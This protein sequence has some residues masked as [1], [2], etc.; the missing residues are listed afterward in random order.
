MS[1]PVLGI[2]SIQVTPT[3]VLNKV[4]YVPALSHYLLSVSELNSQNK[5][6]VTFFPM[7]VIFQ[8]LSSLAIIGKEGL[9]GSLFHL[10]GIYSGEARALSP[11]VALIL[12]FDLVK[13]IWLW[14]RRMGHPSFGVMKKSMP[15]LFFGIKE[16][17][18]H[19]ETCVFAKSHKS[20]YS[21]S[22]SSSFAPFELIHSDVWGPSKNLILT[23]MKYFV[24]LL[25]TLQD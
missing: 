10:D 23:G 12:S 2:G 13:E 25:M 16:S 7:Y 19:C 11:T 8:D 6:S 24:L 9:R 4:L 5:C 14:H 3:I 21:P 20:S 18:L 1:F 15:S 17:S 22:F